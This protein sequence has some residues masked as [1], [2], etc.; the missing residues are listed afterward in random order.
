MAEWL[1]TYDNSWPLARTAFQCPELMRNFWLALLLGVSLLQP[2]QWY[3]IVAI[4]AA[5]WNWVC[6][7]AKEMCQFQY[8]TRAWYLL[9]PKW[10][11]LHLACN[12]DTCQH[13]RAEKKKRKRSSSGHQLSWLWSLAAV[14][15]AFQHE[16]SLNRQEFLR[17]NGFNY[18][19]RILRSRLALWKLL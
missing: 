3:L 17:W 13:A 10:S 16:F 6:Q 19:T 2:T 5:Q 4:S 14:P 18:A 8:V 7:C 15:Q 1:S 9:M 11:F 12:F